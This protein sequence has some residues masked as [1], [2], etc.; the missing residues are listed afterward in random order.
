MIFVSIVVHLAV[1]HLPGVAK[2]A[3]VWLIQALAVWCDVKDMV[4]DTVV[5]NQVAN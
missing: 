2:P 1:Q 4:V 3:T 5:E